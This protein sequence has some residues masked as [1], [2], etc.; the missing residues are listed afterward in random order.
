MFHKIFILFVEIEFQIGINN[1]VNCPI[2]GFFFRLKFTEQY[3][4]KINRNFMNFYDTQ[5]DLQIQKIESIFVNV[6]LP[7]L[8][9]L[10]PCSNFIYTHF[11]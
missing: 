4:Q 3:Q 1:I 8:N 2:G 7:M 6:S 11:S 9:T 5:N 10:V